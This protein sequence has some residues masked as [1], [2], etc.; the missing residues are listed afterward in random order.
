MALT[1]WTWNGVNRASKTTVDFVATMTCK[2]CGGVKFTAE[3]IFDKAPFMAEWTWQQILWMA[4]W[5]WNKATDFVEWTWCQL[6]HLAN[7][8]WDT[9]AWMINFCFTSICAFIDTVSKLYAVYVKS[10]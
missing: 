8:I 4:R 1:A 5:T 6:T 9:I 3:W 2:F 10:K 7:G